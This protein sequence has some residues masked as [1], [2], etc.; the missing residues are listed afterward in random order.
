MPSGATRTLDVEPKLDICDLCRSSDCWSPAPRQL[1]HSVAGLVNLAS[2]ASPRPPK[3]PVPCV[4][5]SSCPLAVAHSHDVQ[6]PSCPV[7]LFIDSRFRAGSEFS[8]FYVYCYSVVSRNTH[9]FTHE[10]VFVIHE[11]E[12]YSYNAYLPVTRKFNYLLCFVVESSFLSNTYAHN[13]F[14]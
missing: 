13:N 14:A 12:F 11:T 9:K 4:F 10:C 3:R 7:L 2:H 8:D 5:S 6:P 1:S